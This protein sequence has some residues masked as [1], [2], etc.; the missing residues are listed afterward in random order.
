LNLFGLTIG[1]DEFGNIFLELDFCGTVDK[2]NKDGN[3][4]EGS[5]QPSIGDVLI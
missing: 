5:G 4:A 1:R 2:K 3:K